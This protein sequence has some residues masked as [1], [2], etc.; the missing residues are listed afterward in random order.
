MVISGVLTRK[1]TDC[2]T[3]PAKSL[4]GF[5]PIVIIMDSVIINKDNLSKFG[6]WYCQQKE[7]PDNRPFLKK[8]SNNPVRKI[9]GSQHHSG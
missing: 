6:I 9:K 5:Q 2:H 7:I 1:A 4:S 3:M 8:T